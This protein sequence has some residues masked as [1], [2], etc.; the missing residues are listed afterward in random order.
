MLG[1]NDAPWKAIPNSLLTNARGT[2]ILYCNNG[3]I[4]INLEKALGKFFFF[5]FIIYWYVLF[6][7]ERKHVKQR[8]KN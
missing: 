5:S 7:P 2:L 8:K 1:T 3:G 6:N 4:R